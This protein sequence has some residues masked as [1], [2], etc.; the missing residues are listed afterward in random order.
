MI[1]LVKKKLNDE[2][3]K[4]CMDIK[5]SVLRLMYAILTRLNFVLFLFLVDVVALVYYVFLCLLCQK[6]AFVK[7]I[8][9]I[10][11]WTCLMSCFISIH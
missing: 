3:K 4:A 6:Q 9:K 5:K 8:R 11:L 7:M 1:E 2:V 10:T